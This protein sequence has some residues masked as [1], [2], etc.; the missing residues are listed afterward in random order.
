MEGEEFTAKDAKDAKELSEISNEVRD[1]YKLED[2]CS[3]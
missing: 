3:R 1:H 2:Y